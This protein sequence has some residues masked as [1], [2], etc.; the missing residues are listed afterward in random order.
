M[1]FDCV[2]IVSNDD[3]TFIW[4]VTFK[5]HDNCVFSM[6]VIIKYMEYWQKLKI[7][8]MSMDYLTDADGT[9]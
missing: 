9:D 3:V 4:A 1:T 5:D 2:F 6:N 8:H 7:S